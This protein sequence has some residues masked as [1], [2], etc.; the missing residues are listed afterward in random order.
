MIYAM[1][2]EQYPLQGENAETQLKARVLVSH[3]QGLHSPTL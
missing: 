3:A 1:S 2:S